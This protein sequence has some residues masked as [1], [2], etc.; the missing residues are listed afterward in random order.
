MTNQRAAK[1]GDDSWLEMTRNPFKYYLR[2]ILGA[3]LVFGALIL[4]A[5]FLSDKSPLLGLLIPAGI[6]AGGVAL[7]VKAW[8]DLAIKMRLVVNAGSLRLMQGESEVLGQLPFDNIA[9]IE[10]VDRVEFIFYKGRYIKKNK[11][12]IEI[13]LIDRKKLDS[14]WPKV[15]R[16]KSFHIEI[17]DEWSGSLFIL[18][19]HVFH[20]VKCYREAKG[21][22]QH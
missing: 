17:I 18:R 3:V 8:K 7:A 10:V 11:W 14:W 13:T 22:G 1:T 4:A 6:A 9:R 21:Y 5:L 16:K 20:G 19:R 2:V 15:V 12:V